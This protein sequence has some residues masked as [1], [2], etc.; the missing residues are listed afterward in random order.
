M[1]KV[2]DKLPLK[3]KKW[4]S[5]EHNPKKQDEWIPVTKRVGAGVRIAFGPKSFWLAFDGMLHSTQ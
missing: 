1:I 5:G 4:L 3:L 2:G